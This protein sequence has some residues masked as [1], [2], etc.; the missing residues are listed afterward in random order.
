MG[1]GIKI[2]GRAIE[3]LH[4]EDNAG[5]A[6]ILRQ[7]LKKAGFPNNLSAVSSGEEVLDFLNQVK[8]YVRAPKPDVIILDLKLPGKDGLSILNEIRQNEGLKKIPVIILTSS[9]SDLDMD[10]AV[11]LNANHYVVKPV[12][13]DGY[14]EIIKILREVWLKTFHKV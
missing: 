5:D 1:D 11:R 7:T 3:V 6:H 13:L 8:F 12:D 14:G 9:E 2:A 10:W 4:A